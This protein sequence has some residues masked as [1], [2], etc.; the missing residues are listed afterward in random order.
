MNDSGLR[1]LA[2]KEIIMGQEEKF[3]CK[4]MKSKYFRL[5]NVTYG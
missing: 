4:K 3:S 2:E 1:Q 5:N